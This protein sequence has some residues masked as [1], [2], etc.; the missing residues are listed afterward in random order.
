M[1]LLPDENRKMKS[2][3]NWKT[4]FIWVVFIKMLATALEPLIENLIKK[5]DE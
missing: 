4:V 3:F 5:E 1:S 2:S